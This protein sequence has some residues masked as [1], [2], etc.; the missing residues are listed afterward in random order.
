MQDNN[1]GNAGAT[2][3][4]IS[5]SADLGSQGVDSGAS[6]GTP[7]NQNGNQTATGNDDTARL[8]DE[9]RRLNKAVVEAKRGNRN[10]PQ[11][12][13]EGNPFETPEGQFGI[14]IQLATGNLRGKME[15][16]FSLYP[17]LP[18]EEVTRIRKNPWAFASHESFVGGDWESAA[19]EIEQAMLERAE[20]IA[21]S[22]PKPNTPIPADV[23]TNP[24]PI[25][26][27]NSEAVPGTPEDEDPW[28]M[29]ME[30]LEVK[31]KKAVAAVS[32]SK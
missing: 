14:A 13:Q 12:G 11:G 20:E 16:L 9:I 5:D 18:A 23:N 10:V 26:E 15:D 8:R 6:S 25:A 3:S 29:P 30:K 17:E 1:D 31:A 7:D 2:T 27:D 28:T 32:K 19:L 24:A 22:K 21:A 4:D